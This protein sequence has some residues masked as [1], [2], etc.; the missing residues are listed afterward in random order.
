MRSLTVVLLVSFLIILAPGTTIAQ[1]PPSPIEDVPPWH[2]AFDAVKTLAEKGIV[3][4]FPRNDRDLSLNAVVQVYE[5]FAHAAHPSA[6]A[7]AE[8]FLT[9]LPAEWPRPLQRSRLDSFAMIEHQVRLDGPRGTVT[10]LIVARLRTGAVSR[11]RISA[12]VR[13]EEAGRW[14][15]DYATLARDHADVFK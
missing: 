6:Q 3:Q 5:A 4:G 15:V 11:A 13:R 10:A 2:W 14:R 12:V 8:A 9:N 7:W 1:T